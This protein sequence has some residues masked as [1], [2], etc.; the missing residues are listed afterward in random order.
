MV[1][2]HR[3]G[4]VRF[5][6]ELCTS[7]ESNLPYSSSTEKIFVHSHTHQSQ[8]H[9]PL[10]CFGRLILMKNVDTEITFNCRN[11]LIEIAHCVSVSVRRAEEK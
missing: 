2:N 3:F 8:S 6:G 11:Q 10:K 9:K 1:S 4:S 7:Q 5:Y